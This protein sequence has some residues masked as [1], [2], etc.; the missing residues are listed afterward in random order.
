MWE[1]TRREKRNEAHTREPPLEAGS[2]KL[3]TSALRHFWQEKGPPRWTDSPV[4]D[5]LPRPKPPLK[6]VSMLGAGPSQKTFVSPFVLLLSPAG[7]R[8]SNATFFSPFLGLHRI[9][10]EKWKAW[11]LPQPTLTA[12]HLTWSGPRLA[13]RPH[14]QH[15]GCASHRLTRAATPWKR[16]FSIG[17]H[18]LPFAVTC[19]S[20]GPGLAMAAAPHAGHVDFP[21]ERILA[22]Q[23]GRREGGKGRG[24]WCLLYMR[25]RFP[26]TRQ[27]GCAGRRGGGACA[28]EEEGGW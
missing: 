27:F 9:G 8:Q 12:S 7:P 11:P 19:V 28:E 18:R 21:A 20:I 1:D 25:E 17:Q 5:H 10:T 24:E 15:P 14:H 3:T 2:E 23:R 16:Q 26:R 4:V 13:S 6:M 22:N